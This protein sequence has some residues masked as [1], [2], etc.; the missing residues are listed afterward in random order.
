M[1]VWVRMAAAEDGE[2][3]CPSF[4]NSALLRTG[5][6]YERPSRVS[7][8]LYVCFSLALAVMAGLLVMMMLSS[9]DAN[10]KAADRAADAADVAALA[11]TSALGT[12]FVSNP[13]AQSRELRPRHRLCGPGLCHRVQE[14]DRVGDVSGPLPGGSQAGRRQ[15]AAQ[16][17]KLAHKLRGP[18]LAAIEPISAL[19]GAPQS[20]L[21]SLRRKPPPLGSTSRRRWMILASPVNFSTISM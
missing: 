9:N 13:L 15:L 5:P 8:A 1:R 6:A 3:Y 7:L 20:W 14:A 12:L 17:L 18:D 16:P 21:A 2:G 10:T 19:L 4:M 11:A